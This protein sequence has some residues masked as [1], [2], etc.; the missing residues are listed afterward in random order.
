MPNL[1]QSN[2]CNS[3]NQNTT[4]MSNF[5]DEINTQACQ[6][7]FEHILNNINLISSK[8]KNEIFNDKKR[9]Y[10]NNSFDENTKIKEWDEICS[11]TSSFDLDTNLVAPQSISPS[12]NGTKTNTSTILSKNLIK[13]ENNFKDLERI[14]LS[15][16][17]FNETAIS[18]QETDDS[19]HE[20][21]TSLYSIQSIKTNFSNES[22]NNKLTI[23]NENLPTISA[24]P[25]NKKEKLQFS[26][27]NL[28]INKS[29]DSIKMFTT[30]QRH[31]NLLQLL[32]CLRMFNESVLVE[33]FFSSLI[34][35]MT[36]EN[37]IPFIYSMDV[38]QIFEK[39]I[40]SASIAKTNLSSE[41][42]TI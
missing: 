35:N 6:E 8:T 2:V 22:D 20:L 12:S 10:I 39:S 4:T 32:P 28:T 17:P 33:L 29:I 38:L 36:I 9:N 37:I 7:L 14:S 26:N 41:T 5:F 16:S 18:S 42:R 19:D 25:I 24:V 21:N 30:V 31:S 1:L 40:L 15:E 3:I 11:S 34:G 13:E 23:N 27:T